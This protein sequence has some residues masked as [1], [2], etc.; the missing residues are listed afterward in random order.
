M[1][2]ASSETPVSLISRQRIKVGPDATRRIDIVMAV[3][4]TAIHALFGCK[5]KVWMAGTSP[6]M[7]P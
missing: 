5:R 3:L 1:M 4:V 7:T 2:L 6:A